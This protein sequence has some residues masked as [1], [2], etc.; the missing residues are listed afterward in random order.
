M[1]VTVPTAICSLHISCAGFSVVG[2][3]VVRGR[4]RPPA[5]LLHAAGKPFISY[6]TWMMQV[7][8]A[9]KIYD[10]VF[11]GGTSINPG[12]RLVDPSVR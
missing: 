2:H 3:S 12:V 6:T 7:T 11:V 8:D 9:G 10:V 4:R 1:L 5:R